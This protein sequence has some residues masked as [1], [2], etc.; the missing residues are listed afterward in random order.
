MTNPTI[1]Q[2][3][4]HAIR[5][6]LQVSMLAID[7]DRK[8]L[9]KDAL[10]D[11]SEI[12]GVHRVITVGLSRSWEIDKEYSVSLHIT[13]ERLIHFELLKNRIVQRMLVLP[14]E[15]ARD[16]GTLLMAFAEE[17]ALDE[18]AEQKQQEV[19]RRIFTDMT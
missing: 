2:T 10:R 18:G 19:K 4:I 1:T 5:Q 17:V 15:V 6:L 16:L 8:T 7:M 14:R 9:A 12:M 11:A 13:P 3:Q